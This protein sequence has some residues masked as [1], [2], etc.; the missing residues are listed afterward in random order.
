MLRIDILRHGETALSGC[1]R[2]ATDDALTQHGWAQMKAGLAHYTE[3]QCALPWQAVFSSPLQRCQDFAAQ[4]AAEHH[5]PLLLDPQLQE[6]HF[7]DWEG[8]STADLYQQFPQAL[9]QFWQQ[10]SQ[11]TP[12]NA[13]PLLQFQQ[14]V[15][16]AMQQIQQQMQAEQWQRVLLISH[17]GVIKLLKNRALAQP[18]DQLLQQ[19]AELG[20]LHGFEYT[21]DAQLQYRGAD[22]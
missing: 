18:L 10:P 3:A 21:A 9:A 1:L 7:G 19:S 20:Q 15:L 17:G 6:M 12:P 14:R 11:F 5:I 22:R 2:G 13:E 16:R 8:Q 4:L